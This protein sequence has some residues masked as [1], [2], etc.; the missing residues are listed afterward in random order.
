MQIAYAYHECWMLEFSPNRQ[1]GKLSMS[2]HPLDDVEKVSIPDFGKGITVEEDEISPRDSSDSIDVKDLPAKE[3]YEEP[4][5]AHKERS[6]SRIAMTLLFIFGSF[7]TLL[8]AGSLC[9]IG[10]AS[11]F[12][13]S[14]GVIDIVS[15][16]IIP[17]IS[18]IGDVGIKLFSPL[19]A[20]VL[21]YY[22]GK[23]E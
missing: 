4:W 7:L 6:A 23:K 19:L 18:A 15:K 3:E 20:F 1:M 13:T 8:F 9:V 10:I 5:R 2:K 14:A 17:L 16:G 22:F 11:I 21:G 12:L